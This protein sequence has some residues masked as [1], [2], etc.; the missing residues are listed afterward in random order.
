MVSG[1]IQAPPTFSIPSSSSSDKFELW[2]IRVP[3]SLD[4]STLDGMTLSLSSLEQSQSKKKSSTLPVI[5]IGDTPMGLLEGHALEVE[6]L[7]VLLPSF[8][9]QPQT[10]KNG[11]HDSEDSAEDDD[12]DEDS[13]GHHTMV[14]MNQSFQ[15]HFQLLPHHFSN[16]NTIKSE[17]SDDTAIVTPL[18]VPSDTQ[19]EGIVTSDE[20]DSIPTVV[21]EC[22]MKIAYAPKAQVQGLKRRWTPRGATTHLSWDPSLNVVTTSHVANLVEDDNDVT[23]STPKSNKKQ[24]TSSSSSP[25]SKKKSS[26]K[27]K[28]EKKDKKEKKKK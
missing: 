1:K 26:K 27:E 7:R 3:Q 11:N 8:K 6:T 5:R 21:K 18:H 15:R 20:S 13:S 28:K 19:I 17:S 2:S 14:P 10:P 12:D 25:S 9:Q 16:N 4:L 23:M 22:N 24:K